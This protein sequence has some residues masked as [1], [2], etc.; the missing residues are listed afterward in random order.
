M[1]R[2]STARPCWAALVPSCASLAC[3]VAS[4]HRPGLLGPHCTRDAS[5]APGTARFQERGGGGPVRGV[6]APPTKPC[7][8]AP[9][10]P[11]RRAIVRAGGVSSASA[12]VHAPLGPGRRFGWPASMLAQATRMR[13]TAAARQQRAAGR[14]QK[15]PRAVSLMAAQ[16]A[17]LRASC[18]LVA[19]SGGRSSAMARL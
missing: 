13:P 1:R 19:T 10:D 4:P 16:A 7:A 8:R 3:A 14:L 11:S 5:C 9:A 12:A 18:W 6:A 17:R 2:P 15:A